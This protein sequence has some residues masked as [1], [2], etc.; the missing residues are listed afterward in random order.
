MIILLNSIYT[1]ILY[2]IN[3]YYIILN[4]YLNLLFLCGL[5]KYLF[6]CLIFNYLSI[7]TLIL[8]SI[9]IGFVYLFRFLSLILL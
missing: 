1:I 3:L 8:H 4:F 7:L 6:N 9:M 2:Y 5:I